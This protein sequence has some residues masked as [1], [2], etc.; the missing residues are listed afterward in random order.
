MPKIS[1]VVPFFNEEENVTPLLAEIRAVCD[2]LGQS[3]EA[4]FVNDGR[5]D[6]TRRRLDEAANGWPEAML[7]PIARMTRTS[8][9]KRSIFC[10]A[11]VVRSSG[12]P[13][14]S[15]LAPILY[16]PGGTGTPNRPSWRVRGLVIPHFRLRVFTDCR[17]CEARMESAFMRRHPPEWR[18]T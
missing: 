12:S 9:R 6:V 17:G 8:V 11:A 2:A 5:K 7:Q 15:V 10:S 16:E 1:I 18:R 4:I 14:N 3:Y 13:R